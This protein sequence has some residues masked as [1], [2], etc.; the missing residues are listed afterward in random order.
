VQLTKRP[1]PSLRIVP[2]VFLRYHVVL[3]VILFQRRRKFSIM[4]QPWRSPV[5]TISSNRGDCDSSDDQVVSIPHAGWFAFCFGTDSSSMTFLSESKFSLV[6]HQHPLLPSAA[7]NSPEDSVEIPLPFVL[8][9]VNQ[10]KRKY[11]G[12]ESTAYIPQSIPL[13]DINVGKLLYLSQGCCVSVKVTSTGVDVDESNLIHRNTASEEIEAP[14]QWCLV[15]F[16][17]ESLPPIDS[18]VPPLGAF[19]TRNKALVC[20]I[21]GKSFSSLRGVQHHV[22]SVHVSCQSNGDE[23]V[24]ETY[25]QGL[26]SNAQVNTLYEQPLSVI[27][28]DAFVAVVNKPQGMT[29]MG[30]RPSLMRSDLLMALIC[31]N[32]EKEALMRGTMNDARPDKALGKPR[33]VHRLD[34]ATGG[35]LV[36]AKTHNADQSLRISFMNRRCHKRYRAILIGKLVLSEADVLPPHVALVQG[37]EYDAVIDAN[38]DGKASQTQLRIVRHIQMHQK[39]EDWFTVVD[40]WP[41]TGRTHQLRKHMKLI[42]FSIYGDTRYKSFPMPK[43]LEITPPIAPADSA[44]TLSTPKPLLCLWAVEITLPH[45]HSGQLMTFQI[46]REEDLSET[47]MKEEEPCR[48]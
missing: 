21:C 1:M 47:Y 30:G 34:N 17:F 12:D 2:N 24:D 25:D 4:S 13:C 18:G 43:N 29:V 32:E 41:I 39:S 37:V 42:G 28:Q 31:T 44:Q 15:H 8:G 38:V 22:R 45:P 9:T 36:I 23:S 19:S 7:L 16:P 10:M 46:P 11:Y 40:L 27:Y 6:I 33:P 20:R 5:L 3:E 26:Q 48:V 14:L 35:L